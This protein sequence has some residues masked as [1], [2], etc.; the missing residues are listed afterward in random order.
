MARLLCLDV[1]QYLV[2]EVECNDLRDYHKALDCDCF[3]IAHLKIGDK[4]F[5]CFVDDNG[6][7]ADDPLPSAIT[8]EKDV[9]LVGNI[10]FANHDSEGNT[11][12]LSDN[13]IKMIKQNIVIGTRT[14]VK[15]GAVDML[16][17]VI[18]EY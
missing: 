7:F 6:L 2:T 3:D 1:K 9:L 16:L 8:K 13:D 4:Y 15:T 12:S 17:M 10:V 5:D 11:T 18:A 14:D